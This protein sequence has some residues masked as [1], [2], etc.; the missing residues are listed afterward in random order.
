[1]PKCTDKESKFEPR[2]HECYI[3]I[4]EPAFTNT[5]TEIIFAGTLLLTQNNPFPVIISQNRNWLPHSGHLR[6]AVTWD[7]EEKLRVRGTMMIT[8]NYSVG[9]NEL[10][11]GF[12]MAVDLGQNNGPIG[13]RQ[14]RPSLIRGGAEICQQSLSQKFY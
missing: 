2:N 13:P 4:I 11:E 3:E 8:S 12:L 9:N 10:Q 14:T 5:T 6:P 7:Q 1:M